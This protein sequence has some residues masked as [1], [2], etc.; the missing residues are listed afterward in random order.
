MIMSVGVPHLPANCTHCKLQN[1]LN[2]GLGDQ[3]RLPSLLVIDLSDTRV[4]PEGLSLF[5]ACHP[6]IL[7]IEHKETFHAFKLV[8][9]KCQQGQMFN[10]QYLSTIDNHLTP[11]DYEYA[12]D[13][14]PRLEGIH[15]H[16][17]EFRRGNPPKIKLGAFKIPKTINFYCCSQG[18]SVI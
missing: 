15:V 4:T 17:V 11:E 7:K 13:H 2:I 6:N 16:R 1:L 9:T 8:K 14:C 12:I 10:L 3:Y 18:Q 5:L